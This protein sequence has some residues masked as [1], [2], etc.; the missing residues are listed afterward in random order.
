MWMA[1]R[2]MLLPTATGWYDDE[3]VR[4]GSG[5]R[6]KRRVCRLLSWTGNP[7][8]PEPNRDQSP[9]MK[10]NTLRQFGQAGKLEFLK[11]ITAK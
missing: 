8:V 10:T 7:A 1:T 11:A 4:T 9:D 6:I 5:W 2:R 3:L